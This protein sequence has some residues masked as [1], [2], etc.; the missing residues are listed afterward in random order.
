MHLLDV[1]D[2]FRLGMKPQLEHRRNKE[3]QQQEAVERERQEQR[4][5]ERRR[6]EQEAAEQKRAAFREE[7]GAFAV[8][9]EFGARDV[10]AHFIRSAREGGPE[11]RALQKLA[12]EIDATLR[13]RQEFGTE[14]LNRRTA[15]LD[16]E[17]P[18][19]AAEDVRRGAV[20]RA[21]RTKPAAFW[22]ASIE[23]WYTDGSCDRRLAETRAR[24][25]PNATEDDAIYQLYTDV[26]AEQDLLHARNAQHGRVKIDAAERK[27]RTELAEQKL[28]ERK[29]S[30]PQA[31]E[32]LR[33]EK[34]FDIVGRRVR[35]EL[36]NVSGRYKL[37]VLQ[38]LYGK[39]GLA[40]LNSD[41]VEAQKNGHIAHP[42]DALFA[43]KV[44]PLID[45]ALH[46]RNKWKEL[47]GLYEGFDAG[48]EQD[49]VWEPDRGS[50][51]GDIDYLDHLIL[52]TNRELTDDQIDGELQL[53]AEKT[54]SREDI[55]RGLDRELPID[56]SKLDG[57]Y[58]WAKSIL[59][60]QAA[61]QTRQA[62]D[63]KFPDTAAGDAGSELKEL[64]N[65][66]KAL[67]QN[68]NDALPEKKPPVVFVENVG[69]RRELLQQAFRA[70]QEDVRRL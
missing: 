30:D 19:D 23:S 53:D 17:F 3:R 51:P 42:E 21:V 67:L 46:D 49:D 32:R 60:E 58:A 24:L 45:E 68:C 28:A 20:Q 15:E 9:E 52:K 37:D 40:R 36:V 69:V 11:Y 1:S 6:A 39:D 38:R 2:F 59:R 12:D 57:G 29:E 25:G 13:R 55:E 50:K 63:E 47:K 65:Q 64:G 70:G 26:R 14:E 10:A 7:N 27:I 61:D 48:R 31:Y 16:K 8:Q 54:I 18:A 56:P 22:K 5:Q 44:V 33:R 41:L 43:E 66:A 4:E 34:R 35:S 62:A